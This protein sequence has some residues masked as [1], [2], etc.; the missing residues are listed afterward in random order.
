MI[1]TV[2]KRKEKG[3]KNA[4]PYITAV[5]YTHFAA[6][7][8]GRPVLFIAPASSTNHVRTSVANLIQRALLFITVQT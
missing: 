2:K 1:K 7:S 6:I 8:A 5:I 4:N 3:I